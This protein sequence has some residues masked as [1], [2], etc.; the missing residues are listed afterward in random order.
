LLLYR[1]EFFSWWMPVSCLASIKILLLTFSCFI[2]RNPIHICKKNCY[3]LQ[4]ANCNAQSLQ[5]S[6]QHANMYS[7]I[8]RIQAHYYYSTIYLHSW[9]VSKVSIMNYSSRNL[10][11]ILYYYNY[12][13]DKIVYLF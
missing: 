7:I 4:S 10:Q 8:R 5:H 12:L 13:Y 2:F 9:N 6:L 11:Y 3:R 1:T